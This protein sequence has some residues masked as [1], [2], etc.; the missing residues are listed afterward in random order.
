MHCIVVCKL[1]F[2]TMYSGYSLSG[3]VRESLG[4][5][6]NGICYSVDCSVRDED[7]DPAKVLSPVPD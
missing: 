4:S 1:F 7:V 3:A 5:W 6:Q 2:E